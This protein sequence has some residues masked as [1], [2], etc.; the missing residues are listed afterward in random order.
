[1]Q[2]R[3]VIGA[4]VNF[5]PED[6]NKSTAVRFRIFSLIYFWDDFYRSAFIFAAAETSSTD[7]RTGQTGEYCHKLQQWIFVEMSVENLP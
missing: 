3:Y 4:A 6:A 5:C 1:M 7:E 2:L